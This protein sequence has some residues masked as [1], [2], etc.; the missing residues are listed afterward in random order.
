MDPHKSAK[1]YLLKF[2]WRKSNVPHYLLRIHTKQRGISL[3]I[4]N[5]HWS[6]VYDEAANMRQQK[7]LTN[8]FAVDIFV[9]T[10]KTKNQPDLYKDVR[11]ADVG[12]KQQLLPSLQ[13]KH[14][15]NIH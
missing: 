8:V 13:L 7:E 3:L 6:L 11:H 15:Q 10:K 9:C 5:A 12:V 2:K 14:F 1:S 4:N